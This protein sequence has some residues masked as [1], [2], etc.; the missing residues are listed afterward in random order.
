MTAFSILKIYSVPLDEWRQP[1]LKQ[2]LSHLTPNLTMVRL[3]TI[4]SSEIVIS[5]IFHF[6]PFTCWTKLKSTFLA[7]SG[8]PPLSWRYW[9]WNLVEKSVTK[10]VFGTGR[11]STKCY[12]T[13]YY[14]R[15]AQLS[16]ESRNTLLQN[17]T[18]WISK[19][20]TVVCLLAACRN[21]NTAATILVPLANKSLLPGNGSLSLLFFFSFF[22]IKGP[23]IS[24]GLFVV[25]LISFSIQNCM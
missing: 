24:L 11:F 13:N 6:I 17:I 20:R 19:L 22:I 14:C 16:M 18:Q 1:A 8:W 5:L 12:K 7:L 25:H 3:F 15:Q 21:R 9:S 10:P 2:N 4:N 23:D